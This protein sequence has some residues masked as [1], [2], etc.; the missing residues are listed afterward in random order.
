M[1]GGFGVR[2][3]EGKIAAAGYAREHGVP[4]LGL[5]LGL[6]CAVIEFARDDVRARRRELVGVRPAHARTR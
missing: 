5:C 2:G 1:P 3:I 4:Y 6:H